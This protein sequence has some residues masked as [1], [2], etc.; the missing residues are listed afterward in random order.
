MSGQKRQLVVHQSLV[1]PILFGGAERELAIIN[2]LLIVMLI[3][4]GNFSLVGIIIAGLLATV[5]HASLV[6]AAKLDSQLVRI[7]CRHIRYKDYYPAL[8]THSARSWQSLCV[9]EF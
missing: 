2:V 8:S 1:K 5:G 3:V 7:Y 6:A 4:G 9:K